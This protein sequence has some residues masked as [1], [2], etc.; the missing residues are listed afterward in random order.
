MC[1]C[2]MRAR[3]MCKGI[4]FTNNN[5]VWE[6]VRTLSCIGK[7]APSFLFISPPLFIQ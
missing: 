7:M 3:G 5:T 2:V 6:L 1:V 4:I